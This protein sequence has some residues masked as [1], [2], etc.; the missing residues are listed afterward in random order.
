MKKDYTNLGHNADNDICECDDLHCT[1][2]MGTCSQPAVHDMYEI[3]DN[4]KETESS[5]RMC[6]E[7]GFISWEN[8]SHIADDDNPERK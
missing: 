2:C 5:V 1:Y 4:G 8:G 6:A 3:D 7:C